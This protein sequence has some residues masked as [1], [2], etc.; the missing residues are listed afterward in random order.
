M[1][2]SILQDRKEC[3]ITHDTEG[4]HKHHIMRGSRRKAAEKW[5]CWIWLR[6]DWHN[7]AAYGVHNNPR[8]EEQ[9]RQICQMRF[10]ELHW[11]DK[12]M[13]VFGKN[14]LERTKDNG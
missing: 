13:E 4:L 9:L 11:H 1:A 5:G 10:E 7:M 8:L 12:W 2:D 3:Y 14:Y 6:A